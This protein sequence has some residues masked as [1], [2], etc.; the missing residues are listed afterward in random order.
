M[1]DIYAVDTFNTKRFFELRRAD[2]H[3]LYWIIRYYDVPTG[4]YK[5][6]Q[7]RDR[8]RRWVRIK[9]IVSYNAV[10]FYEEDLG[11]PPFFKE[12]DLCIK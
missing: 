12:I 8:R 5:I 2:D 10:D 6:P 9:G 3:K 11:G 4:C 7:L 1:I